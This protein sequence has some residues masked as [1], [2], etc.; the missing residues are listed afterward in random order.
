MV[1]LD[2]FVRSIV[3]KVRLDIDGILRRVNALCLYR[4]EV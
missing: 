3:Y 1:I 2:G 4:Y